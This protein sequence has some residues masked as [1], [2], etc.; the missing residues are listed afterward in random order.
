MAARESANA[1]RKKARDLAAALLEAED[2]ERQQR[3][4]ERRKRIT[5]A[6]ANIAGNDLEIEEL[7]A[8]ITELRADTARQLAA[9]V[10]DGVSEA[11]TAEM[12]GREERVVKAAAKAGTAARTPSPKRAA[13]RTVATQAAA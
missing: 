12:T 8:R 2:A 6:A 9:I 4:R 10:A 1:A 3:E 13:K 5:E 7:T 11:K